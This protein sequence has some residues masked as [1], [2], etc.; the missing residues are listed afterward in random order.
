M[1]ST[2]SDSDILIASLA[3]PDLFAEL[4][5]RYQRAFVRKATSILGNEDDAYDAVQETFVRV[6]VSA[7]KFKKQPGASF[8]SWA[9][10]ILVNQCYTAYRKIHRHEA[11]SFDFAPELVETTPDP[12]AE[13]AVEQA[14]SADY[15]ARIISKLP[16]ILRRIVELYFVQG[17]PQKEIALQEG[18]SNSVVRQRIYRAKK[19]LRKIDARQFAYVPT[20]S[21]ASVTSSS[22]S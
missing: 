10:A 14:F 21:S 17:V 20:A 1:D 7:K 2:L 11:I 18:I 15:V 16:V 3:K 9:Y 22:L 19:E 13:R 5:E 4:V 6:Y 8:S 12:Y